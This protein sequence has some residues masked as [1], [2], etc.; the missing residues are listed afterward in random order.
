[1]N[2]IKQ[3]IRDAKN[4]DGKNDGENFIRAAVKEGVGGF[5]IGTGKNSR[6]NRA[7]LKIIAIH[8]LKTGEGSRRGKYLEEG[9]T[10]SGNM[11]VKTQEVYSVKG[12][13]KAHVKATHFM[14]IATDETVKKMPRIFADYCETAINKMK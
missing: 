12:K 5:V 11:V 13:R 2:K 7:L 14:K 9:K 8:R 1:M 4:E 3:Y 10:F 6:G